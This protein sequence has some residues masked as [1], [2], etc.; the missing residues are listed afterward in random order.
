M[1]QWRRAQEGDVSRPTA[2]RELAELGLSG[3]QPPK[4]RSPKARSRAEEL[5]STELDKLTDPSAPDEERKQRKRQLLKG[6][7]EFRDMRDEVRKSKG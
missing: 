6:P 4:A 7:R 5:A 3:T 1:D 2:I